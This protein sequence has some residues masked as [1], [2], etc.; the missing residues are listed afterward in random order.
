[1]KTEVKNI[2]PKLASELLLT[3]TINRPLRVTTVDAYAD[4][5]QRGQWALNGE[6]IIISSQ[7]KLMNGQHRLSAVV[8]CGLSIPF[9]VVSEVDGSVFATLDRG[10]SRSTADTF[11]IRNITNAASIAGAIVTYKRLSL[12]WNDTVGTPNR[13]MMK[14]TSVDSL[15]EYDSS[16]ELWQEIGHKTSECYQKKR[17]LSPSRIGGY[18][19]YLIKNKRHDSDVVFSFFSQLFTNNNITNPTIPLLREKL[20]DGKLGAYNLTPKYA[21][22]IIIKTW[23]LYI[24]E[25]INKVIK[26]SETEQMPKFL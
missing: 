12:G 2:T 7:G 15:I 19:A 21:E 13:I 9:L 10:K 1:M 3:N 8:K 4:A 22:A 16:P 20:I 11:Y 14:L 25:K 26:W 23:N 5:M 18:M 17:L 6:A 24:Q